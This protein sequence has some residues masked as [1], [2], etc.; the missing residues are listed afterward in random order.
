MAGEARPARHVQLLQPA[1]VKD[2]RADAADMHSS[3]MTR[4]LSF[5]STSFCH[6]TVPLQCFVLVSFESYSFVCY[7]EKETA[8]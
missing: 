1:N 4:R 3:S 5:L 6:Y 2:R 7:S 8:S